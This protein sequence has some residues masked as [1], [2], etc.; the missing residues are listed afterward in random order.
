M[1]NQR[2]HAALHFHSMRRVEFV[3][4]IHGRQIVGDV[5]LMDLLIAM[6]SKLQP[7]GRV[8]PGFDALR[9]RDNISG[10]VRRNNE[11]GHSPYPSPPP[12]SSKVATLPP[13]LEMVTK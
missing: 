12:I 2:G 5:D 3:H 7:C 1:F 13:R 6:R 4:L 11:F 8:F 10:T 9:G